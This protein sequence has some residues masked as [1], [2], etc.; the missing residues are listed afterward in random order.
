VSEGTKYLC[1][2]VWLSDHRQM[3][4][5]ALIYANHIEVEFDLRQFYANFLTG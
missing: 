1:P 5:M 4:V 3:L 2:E